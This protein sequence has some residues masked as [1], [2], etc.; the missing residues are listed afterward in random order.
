MQ[1][2]F[3]KK[4]AIIGGGWAGMAASVYATQAGHHATVFEATQALG[5]RARV[6]KGELP[7]GQAIALDN[8]QHIMIG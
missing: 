1:S 5:G 3:K 4:I 8:G 2:G 7:N 6:V